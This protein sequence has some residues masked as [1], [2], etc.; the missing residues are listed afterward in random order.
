M[1]VLEYY[2]ART[3][4]SKTLGAI[5]YAPEN[6]FSL[7]FILPL[8]ILRNI[9]SISERFVPPWIVFRYLGMYVLR[10]PGAFHLRALQLGEAF[11]GTLRLQDLGIQDS[12]LQGLQGL[13][14]KESQKGRQKTRQTNNIQA[15]S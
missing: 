13:P 15:T 10:C 9:F 1:Y 8:C 11:R 14:G 5:I 4:I 6:G 12:S 7:V 2:T 3:D